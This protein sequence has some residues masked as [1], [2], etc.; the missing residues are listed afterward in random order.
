MYQSEDPFW[1]ASQSKVIR[2]VVSGYS[3]RCGGRTKCINV[4]KCWIQSIPACNMSTSDS[5][6]ERGST[7]R[8]RRPGRLDSRYVMHHMALCYLAIS[9]LTAAGESSQNLRGRSGRLQFGSPARLE[10]FKDPDSKFAQR[11]L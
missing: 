1:A 2:A 4:S 10:W 11:L 7:V 9:Q 5:Q 3:P 6:S 8:P